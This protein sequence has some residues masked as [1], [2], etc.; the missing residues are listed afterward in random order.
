[1]GLPTGE[2]GASLPG[3]SCLQH[4]R[5]SLDPDGGLSPLALP[6]PPLS[7]LAGCPSELSVERQH[8]GLSP[9]CQGD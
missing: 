5:R 9:K 2:A 8:R 3:P 1:M 7:A 4:P 6:R